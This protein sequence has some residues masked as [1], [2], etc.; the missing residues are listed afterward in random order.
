MTETNSTHF[1][2]N[3]CFRGDESISRAVE[4]GL[5]P[6]EIRDPSVQWF[7]QRTMDLWSRGEVKDSFQ[8]ISKVLQAIDSPYKADPSIGINAAGGPGAYT[9]VLGIVNELKME[10]KADRVQSVAHKMLAD[11]AQCPYK[12]VEAVH[13]HIDT[14]TGLNRVTASEM[15]LA[16]ICEDAIQWAQQPEARDGL[17][18]PFPL[19]TSWLQTITDEVIWLMAG[20][21][22]GKTAL[23]LK[24]WAWVAEF[25]GCRT[26][27][28][29]LE[30]GGKQ[31]KL[32]NRVLTATLGKPTD[33]MTTYEADL[34]RAYVDK[35]EATGSR[36]TAAP[37]SIEK[38]RAYAM[39]AA[40]DGCRLLFIDNL[41]HIRTA[42]KYDGET[43]KF[44][45]L[46]LELKHIRDD[47][48]IPICILHHTNEEGKTG[49][50]R[51]IDKDSD[52]TIKMS[53]KPDESQPSSPGT[54]RR[55]R[56]K[57]D[58]EKNRDG[59]TPNIDVDFYPHAM[60]Y[61]QDCGK[62]IV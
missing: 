5:M 17:P 9:D 32:M 16:A 31:R 62:G 48:G 45:A 8:I 7:W 46:S 10:S 28:I 30:D 38:I 37:N 12:A 34:C 50:S 52:I 59:D 57:I 60:R 4:A 21:S 18:W 24:W 26:D 33:Q 55:D 22:V 1:L 44:M 40:S 29:G 13:G 41:R 19:L 42:A 47:A 25:V 15:T 14:L 61:D 51:D 35:L 39:Q 36:I 56:I 6:E 3:I 11:V 20:P 49:W 53:R 58:V 43:Q 2:G 23:A 27:Y 54:P